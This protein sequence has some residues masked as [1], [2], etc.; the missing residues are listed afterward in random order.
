MN[1]KIQ[2]AGKKTK[3]EQV[4]IYLLNQDSKKN[5]ALTEEFPEFEYIAKRI[6][7][8]KK[9]SE[10]F[11]KGENL[12]IFVAGA[13]E[14]N[15][16]EPIEKFRKTGAKISSLISSNKLQNISI[17]NLSET[18]TLLK[19]FVEGLILANYRFEKYLTNKDKHITPFKNISIVDENFSKKDASELQ[20]LLESIYITRD[21]VNEP[22]NFLTAQKLSEIIVEL[23]NATGFK[24][25]VFN[26][27]KI[28]SLKMGGL[29]AVNKG[30]LENPTFNIM[31]WKPKNASNSKP[32]VLVGKGVTY[33]TGGTSLKP[34]SGMQTMKCDMA[35][36]A[37][38]VGLM[39]AIAKNELPVYVVA[40]IPATDNKLDNKAIV[41]GDIITM[42][43]GHSVE[44]LNT[45]AE[46]RLILADALHFA[47]KY[48]PELVID[49]ATLTGAAA[50]AIGEHGS[51]AFQKDAKD[52]LENLKNAGETTYERIVEFPLW[53]EYFDQITSDIADLK[54]I[55]GPE[56]GAN[57]AAKFLEFFT[58]YPW[59]HIDIAGPSFLERNAGYLVKGGT[60]VGVRMVY[61]FI[62]QQAKK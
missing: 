22:V 13:S 50:R 61:E 45:D 44:V 4:K 54:N 53:Q 7:D 25:E 20:N 17:S 38:V 16:S 18:T 3:S 19:S 41:P 6:S 23:G 24:T 35:G 59:I 2:V 51:V 40:L 12:I 14:N 34:S 49:F 37:T 26:K 11:F 62:N 55:G 28:E 21:L 39:Y 58:D 36:A 46:G 33:D 30:S 9:D 57:T 31:E 32:I 52:A 5:E 48:K 42:Y 56:G 27:K 29:L 1:F 15:T 60:G 8:L 47:K 43:S 10:H